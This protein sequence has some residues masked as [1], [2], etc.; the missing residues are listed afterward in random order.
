MLSQNKKPLTPEQVFEDIPSDHAFKTVTTEIF[1]HS[2]QPLAS[3]HP[4]KH[5]SV[6][7]KFIDRMDAAQAARSGSPEPTAGSTAEGK[8]KQWGIGKMVR[9]VTGGVQS[10]GGA[11]KKSAAGKEG[12]DAV[13]ETGLQ[14]DFYLVIVSGSGWMSRNRRLTLVLPV[15][16]VPQVHCQHCPDH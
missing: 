8:K 9:K 6:M 12:E 5:A 7:K 11:E 15:F 3:V 1:P 10:A 2:G 13:E 16:T 4:C 14:V